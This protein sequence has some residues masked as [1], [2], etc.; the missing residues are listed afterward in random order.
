MLDVSG[1]VVESTLI[2]ALCIDQLDA[3]TK[4]SFESVTVDVK[5]NLIRFKHDAYRALSATDREISQL[6]S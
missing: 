6:I 3:S 4:Q 5:E 1:I 2:N